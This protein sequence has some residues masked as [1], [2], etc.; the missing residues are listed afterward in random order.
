MGAAAAPSRAPLPQPAPQRRR[1]ARRRRATR[2][3]RPNRPNR[4]LASS[5]PRRARTG[6]PVAARVAQPALA[7]AAR[8]P[9]A[10]VRTAGA[11]RDISDSSP[12]I[13]LTSGRGWIA[14][15]GAL[16]FGIVALNVVS[17]SLNA[18]NG[19]IG[20]EID[21]LE[22]Q[23]SALRAEL[24]EQFSAG[25][26]EGA[27]AELGLAVPDPQDVRYVNAGDSNAEKLAKLLGTD[28]FLASGPTGYPVSGSDQSVAYV[29]TASSEPAPAPTS[30]SPAPTES[31]PPVAAAPAPSGGGGTGGTS[32]GVGL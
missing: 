19:R 27:A 29:P 20:T 6:R 31:A 32:G 25:R 17:L 15:L 9:H 8:L 10:A 13:R 30:S 12:I 11:V 7:G 21:L 16:L 14:L 26:V 5:R 4:A 23:N 28:S 1:P 3:K 24:A 2:S 18:G 22:R